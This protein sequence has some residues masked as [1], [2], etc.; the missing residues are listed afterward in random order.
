MC[1]CTYVQTDDVSLSLCPTLDE[2]FYLPFFLA[3]FPSLSLCLCCRL[4]QDPCISVCMVREC[5]TEELHGSSAFRRVLND[6][7]LGR[8]LDKKQRVC[9]FPSLVWVSSLEEID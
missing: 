5:M 8:R 2:T 9:S 6:L 1:T 7:G 4:C 3:F